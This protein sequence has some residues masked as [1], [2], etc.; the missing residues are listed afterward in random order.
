[1]RK[2]NDR[3]KSSRVW[4]SVIPAGAWAIWR[5]RNDVVF[6][7]ATFYFENL[8]ETTTQCIR[9]WGKNICGVRYIQIEDN[10]FLISE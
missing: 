8:W 7:G 6:K 4:L 10:A 2:K 1:M 9:D 3:S 5:A